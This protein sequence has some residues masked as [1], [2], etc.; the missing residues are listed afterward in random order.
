MI[1]SNWEWCWLAWMSGPAL[2]QNIEAEEGVWYLCKSSSI[3][4]IDH[5]PVD[6]HSP[7]CSQ[8][9]LLCLLDSR[10][11]DFFISS[12]FLDMLLICSCSYNCFTAFGRTP[13]ILLRMKRS[14]YRST[15][16]TLKP[17]CRYAEYR[18]SAGSRKCL[19]WVHATLYLCSWLVITP[20]LHLRDNFDF[21][22]GKRLSLSPFAIIPI[23]LSYSFECHLTS[24]PHSHH[25]VM[26][27]N[28]NRYS[29]I[30]TL[31]PHRQTAY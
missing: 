30:L 12:C 2:K 9:Y 6:I 24:S 10:K 31:T 25:I 3:V 8:R 7:A 14:K 5:W 17:L 26:C 15:M 19:F 23:F 11:E 13:G 21:G 16:L 28:L 29:I 22:C 20:Y 27:L 4:S 18:L 1:Q